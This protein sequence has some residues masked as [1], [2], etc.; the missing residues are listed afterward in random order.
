MTTPHTTTRHPGKTTGS[1]KAKPAPKDAIALLRADHTA[2]ND[3]RK[4]ALLTTRCPVTA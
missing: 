1:A 3:A 2:V 4:E